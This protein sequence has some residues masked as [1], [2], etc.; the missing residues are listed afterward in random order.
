M[1]VTWPI[2]MLWF[3]LP[4][5]IYTI[6]WIH[7]YN[8]PASVRGEA[9]REPSAR[10][11]VTAEQVRKCLLGTT[12]LTPSLVEVTDISGGCGTSFAITVVADAFASVRLLQRHRMIHAALG[13]DMMEKIHALQLKCHTPQQYSALSAPETAEPENS[14]ARP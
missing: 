8:N 14:P 10:A 3:V 13:G 7:N 11:M 4:T 1:F 6:T 12:A 2:S 5:P 9:Q